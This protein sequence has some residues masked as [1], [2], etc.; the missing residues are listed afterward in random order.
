MRVGLISDTHIPDRD[1]KLPL[2]VIGA[3]KDVDLIIHAGDLYSASVLDDLEKIAPVIAA[4]GDDDWIADDH[5]LKDKQILSIEGLSVWVIHQ[6]AALNFYSKGL[7]SLEDATEYIKGYSTLP[8]I[9]VFGHSHK[10]L[11]VKIQNTLFI[12]PGSA[13]YPDHVP[14]L[15]TVSILAVS[16][17]KYELETLP[18]QD[19]CS[20]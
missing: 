17:G 11:T 12:N 1:Q 18:L 5:R 10:A 19:I 14:T 4:R 6:F 8:D 3:F 15:G 9:F 20:H 16:S 2:Q 13:T 7:I